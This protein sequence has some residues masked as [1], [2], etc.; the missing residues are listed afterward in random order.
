MAHAD[1]DACETCRRVEAFN[2]AERRLAEWAHL[3]VTTH[4]PPNT[5]PQQ[6]LVLVTRPH[7][8]GDLIGRI[9][10][11]LDGTVVE[12][13]TLDCC[14]ARRRTPTSDWPKPRCP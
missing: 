4:Y 8:T 2:P 14:P 1:R 3:D 10:L 13:L 9:E 12:T 11:H 5:A 7:S 6:G